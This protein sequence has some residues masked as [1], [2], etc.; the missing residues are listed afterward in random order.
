MSRPDHTAFQQSDLDPFL[1]AEVGIEMNGSTLTMLSVLARLGQDPRTEAARWSRLPK[2][3]AVECLIAT[4][5]SIPLLSQTAS[6]TRAVAAR[7]VMLLPAQEWLPDI[8]TASLPTKAAM[9]TFGASLG[10]T[11]LPRWLPMV[12]LACALLLGIA[13][14]LLRPPG[15]GAGS[16]EITQTKVQA[17]AAEPR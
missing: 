12:L 2:A 13:F 17:P 7:L 6:E 15:G 14:N 4:I 9:R 16:P 3:A 5:A 8:K 10:V 1:F 11:T